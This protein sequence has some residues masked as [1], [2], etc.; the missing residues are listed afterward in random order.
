MV[1]LTPEALATK[2][3]AGDR[4][5]QGIVEACAFALVDPIDCV[6]KALAADHDVRVDRAK[7]V[8]TTLRT[9]KA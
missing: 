5:A 3:Y 8:L 1:R 2:D 9:D 6:A 7:D 4:I